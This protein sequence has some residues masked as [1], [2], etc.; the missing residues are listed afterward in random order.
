MK[1]TFLSLI[2]VMLLV[3]ATTVPAVAAQTGQETASVS[4]TAYI[5]GTI[6]DMGATPGIAFGSIVAGV[7]DTEETEQTSGAVPE[8]S[9]TVDGGG[10][11]TSMTKTGEDWVSTATVGDIVINVTD[12][13]FAAIQV[14]GG[15]ET[16]T[17]TALSGG[18][19]DTWTNGDSYAIYQPE[20]T[21]TTTSAGAG[22][23]INDTGASFQ[24]TVDEGMIAINVT[25]GAKAF[26]AAEVL[27]D[28]LLTT[29]TLTG[30]DDQIWDNGD[31][32]TIYSAG[33]IVFEAAAENNANAT[34]YIKSAAALFTGGSS[35]LEDSNLSWAEDPGLTA[36][37]LST[38]LTTSFVSVGDTVNFGDAGYTPVP[39]WLDIPG[40]QQIA[41]YT[42]AVDFSIDS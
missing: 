35:D 16:I 34:Y 30:G 2:A 24:S 31:T 14:I 5:S 15:N 3:I 25:S 26:V 38:G 22:T 17:T 1:R 40:G 27:S 20:D 37:A 10:S 21:G 32:Y 12:G 18:A 7:S 6:H 33:A 8:D 41:S 42:L 39:L 11:S 36:P 4:V 29:E 13:S 9:G 19:D 28:V 23:A